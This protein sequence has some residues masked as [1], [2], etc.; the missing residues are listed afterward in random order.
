MIRVVKCLCEFINRVDCYD[1]LITVRYEILSKHCNLI[2]KTF[3][4]EEINGQ[5]ENQALYYHLQASHYLYKHYH[6]I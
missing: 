1:L 6:T 2:I 4:C 5:A 3:M